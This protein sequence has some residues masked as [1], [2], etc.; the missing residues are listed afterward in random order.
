MTEVVN[1]FIPYVPIA[2][3]ATTAVVSAL[4]AWFTARRSVRVEVEK[5]KLGAQQKILEQLVTARLSVYPALYALMSDLVKAVHSEHEDSLA[6]ETVLKNVNEWD[7][8]HSILLGPHTTNVCYEFR[9]SLLHAV[10]NPN[11]SSEQYWPVLSRKAE[12][13]ELALRSDLG[14]YGIELA[15]APGSLNTPRIEEY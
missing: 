13:L 8:K 4:V 10:R 5:L 3:A 2:A 14:I 11:I 6:L 9:Q 7:S 12:L 1:P 15:P